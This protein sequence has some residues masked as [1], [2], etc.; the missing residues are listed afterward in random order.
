MPEK[1]DPKIPIYTQ[2]VE[3]LKNAIAKGEYAPRDKIPSVRDLAVFYGVN[4]NTL[5]RALSKLED[6]GLLYSER[7]SG[8]FVTDNL[9]LI[10]ALKEDLPTSITQKYIED[11]LNAG[12]PKEEIIN[13]L[14]KQL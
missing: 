1:F 8:R 5:Q 14:N 4:P 2:L 9:D 11:M 12:I 6:M 10:E 7:T 13:H 3:R